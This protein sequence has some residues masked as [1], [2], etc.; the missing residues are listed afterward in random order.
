MSKIETEDDLA[1]NK[2]SNF[3]IN[4]GDNCNAYYT[5]DTINGSVEIDLN[6]P[7]AIRGIRIRFRGESYVCWQN[8]KSHGNFENI[9]HHKSYWNQLFTI[10]G[11]I[12]KYHQYHFA[13]HHLF[14]Y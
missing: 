14:F 2:I 7:I 4:F 10:W 6:V 5:S 9:K 1:A 8:R 12:C 3:K 13:A 11:K